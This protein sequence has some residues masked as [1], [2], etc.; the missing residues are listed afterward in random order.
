ML[1]D[2]ANSLKSNQKEHHHRQILVFQ[3]ERFLALRFFNLKVC[4]ADYQKLK[5]LQL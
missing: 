2:D 5:N 4:P 1:Q 3:R